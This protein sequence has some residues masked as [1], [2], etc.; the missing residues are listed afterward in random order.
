MEL[1]QLFT[2][3]TAE[4]EGT[5]HDSEAQTKYSTLREFLG[6]QKRRT[7]HAST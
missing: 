2:R 6:I 4:Y 7:D 3:M 1:A 5:K